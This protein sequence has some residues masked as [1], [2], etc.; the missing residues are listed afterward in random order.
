MFQRNWVCVCK[1]RM[2]LPFFVIWYSRIVAL[3]EAMAEQR[4]QLMQILPPLFLKQENRLAIETEELLNVF[5]FNCK[6]GSVSAL[7]RP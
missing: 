3:E 4:G 6:T 2:S 7:E 1:P 5:F